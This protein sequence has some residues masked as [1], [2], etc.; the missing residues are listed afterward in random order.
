MYLEAG[1][2]FPEDPYEQ[3]RYE[4]NWFL[5][6]QPC[7]TGKAAIPTIGWRQSG[8]SLFTEFQL[9]L[10]VTPTSFPAAVF[11]STLKLE[12][13]TITFDCAQVFN[14]CCL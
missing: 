1:K 13:V 2:V 10:T 5:A 9:R 3:L 11:T 8:C 7:F 6:C 14:L 12:S 4:E